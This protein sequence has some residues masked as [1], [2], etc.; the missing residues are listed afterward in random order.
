[1]HD[2]RLLLLLLLRLELLL[3]LLT[4]LLLLLCLKGQGVHLLGL[5]SAQ[6]WSVQTAETLYAPQPVRCNG[7]LLH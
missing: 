5:V 1:M 7:K 4:L 2:R 6:R 3:L